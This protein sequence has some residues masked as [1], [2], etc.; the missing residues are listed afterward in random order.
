VLEIRLRREQAE[1][2]QR[3]ND[4]SGV[5]ERT[6]ESEGASALLRPGGSG[7]QCV[8][9]CRPQALADAV[10]KSQQEDC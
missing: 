9:R 3:T 8:A 5:V 1:R 7:D 10:E 2:E 6:V 4:G